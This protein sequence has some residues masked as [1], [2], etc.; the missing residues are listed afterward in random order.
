MDA[1]VTLHL[2]SPGCLGA[3]EG[4]LKTPNVFRGKNSGLEFTCRLTWAFGSR[5]HCLIGGSHSCT[6]R[7]RFALVRRV[8]RSAWSAHPHHLPAANSSEDVVA[9]QVQVLDA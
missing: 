9:A 2:H 4:G 1:R 5:T 7:A 6:P 3:E 8:Y